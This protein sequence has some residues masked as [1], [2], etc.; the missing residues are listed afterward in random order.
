MQNQVQLDSILQTQSYV[1]NLVRRLA[2]E[3]ETL[4]ETSQFIENLVEVK[5][6]NLKTKPFN[7]PSSL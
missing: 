2:G 4:E 7:D 3:N 6:E 1:L 5:R